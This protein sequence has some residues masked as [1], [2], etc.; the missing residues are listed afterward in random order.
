V[1][2]DPCL[3]EEEMTMAVA[4][5]RTGAVVQLGRCADVPVALLRVSESAVRT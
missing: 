4:R 3:V 2:G 1:E 5:R